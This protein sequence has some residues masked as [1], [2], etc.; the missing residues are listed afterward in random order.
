MKHFAVNERDA[1]TCLYV[2]CVPAFSG[3]HCQGATL[4]ELRANLQEVVEM[5]LEH[6]ALNSAVCS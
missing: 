4:D 3:A 5:L 1:D 6:D 2:G